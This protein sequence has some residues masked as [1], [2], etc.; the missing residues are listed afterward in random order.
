LPGLYG[1]VEEVKAHPAAAGNV[2]LPVLA[3]D[4]QSDAGAVV[5][6]ADAAP[7]WFIAQGDKPIGPLDGA[8]LHRMTSAGELG[9]ESLV[10]RDGMPNWLPLWQ[11]PELQFA[12]GAA[13]WSSQHAGRSARAVS[14]DGANPQI[15]HPMPR[16][17]VLA[18]ASLMLGLIWVCGVGSLLATIFGAVS[19]S[20]IIRSNG[21]KSGKGLAVAGLILGVLGLAATAL[22][23]LAFGFN[24]AN[25]G[26]VP[27]F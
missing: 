12:A 10:W 8:T 24:Y 15:F 6:V 20:Q 4:E 27:G 9:P 17:S 2:E 3:L 5:P 22:L 23:I 7:S 13:A 25:S 14:A 1:K 18:V 19:L 26:R 11:V 21:S 16:T